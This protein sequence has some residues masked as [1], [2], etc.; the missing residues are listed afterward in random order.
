MESWSSSSRAGRSNGR[1]RDRPDQGDSVNGRVSYPE[2]GA[3][4]SPIDVLFIKRCCYLKFG[5]GTVL[6]GIRLHADCFFRCWPL[7]DARM[8]GEGYIQAVTCA[9]QADPGQVAD[10]EYR[11]GA[12]EREESIN[13]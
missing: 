6:S 8:D 10:E 7:R 3:Q 4:V 1:G 11:E 2:E 5:G 9:R 13:I 12:V